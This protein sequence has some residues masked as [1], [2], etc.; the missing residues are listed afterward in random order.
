MLWQILK[1]L[2][3]LVS[4]PSEKYSP[5]RFAALYNIFHYSPPLRGIIVNYFIVFADVQVNMTKKNNCFS[6]YQTD[7]DCVFLF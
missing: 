3:P 1:Q 7:Q 4:V 5:R 6:L 2:F